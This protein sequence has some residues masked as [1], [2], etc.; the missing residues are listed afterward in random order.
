MNAKATPDAVAPGTPA[1]P[2]PKLGPLGA[3]PALSETA[4]M[5]QQTVHRFA[6]DVLRPVGIQLDRM[7]PDAAIA[8][9]SPFWAARKQYLNLGFSI[10]TI[11]ELEPAER[12]QVMS[13]LFE[14]LGWGDAGLAIS[15]GAGLL[16][17]FM[18]A[19]FGNRFLMERFPDTMLGCWGIT[20]PD[21]GSDSLDA[22]RM[23]FHAQGKYG[24][25][26]CVATLDGD[27]VVINGQKSAW[28]SNGTI[29]EV[30]ILYCAADSG[31]GPD[32]QRG[33][34]V[35]V[36]MDAPGVTR[37]KPLDK[38]GQRALNQG[39]IYFDNVCL[40]KDYLL[41]GPDNYL[42]AVYA[43]HTFANSIMATVFAGTA[44]SAYELALGYAHERKQGGVPII[45]HQSVAH[46]LFHLARKVECSRALAQRVVEYNLTNDP[47][48]LHAGMMA[49]VTSTQHAFEV[50]SDALQIFGG[51]GLTREYPIEKIL[52]D[53]RASLIEDGCNEVLAIKGG[54]HLIDEERL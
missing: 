37:G 41:A 26:N 12:A 27:S 1:S 4:A 10:A 33:C 42:Q 8:P 32:T 6:E 21:H 34:V 25:P 39:E 43:I 20:E 49:K 11:F 44:R 3:Q 23:I 28:V 15:I 50:A 35:Y 51:N 53:A 18:A 16:P 2:K 54:F 9:E 7:T 38:I 52:R 45:R 24:R 48:A 14:E 22:N 31:D 5:V 19:A 36:P 46:R 47:P 13:V 29:A 17:A 30:C 40:S